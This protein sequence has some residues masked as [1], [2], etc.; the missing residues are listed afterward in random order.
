M[1][2]PII[3][4]Q[5]S[6]FGEPENDNA[7]GKLTAF[8]RTLFIE[9]WCQIGPEGL[10]AQTVRSRL[11]SG[12][13]NERAV[14]EEPHSTNVRKSDAFTVPYGAPGSFTWSHVPASWDPYFL[15][16]MRE[17]PN[18]ATVEVV[19]AAVG[20]EDSQCR[21]ECDTALMKLR[22]AVLDDV[23][24]ARNLF[25]DFFGEG[26]LDALMEKFGDSAPDLEGDEEF[27]NEAGPLFGDQVRGVA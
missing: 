17:N 19:G 1:S 15:A 4:E 7:S 26:A 27:D 3:F 22:A 8:G 20:L 12:W 16:F 2:K 24:D 11:R 6:M 18:G 25:V 5:V 23:G 14:S 13:D 21:S 9:Q 10:D